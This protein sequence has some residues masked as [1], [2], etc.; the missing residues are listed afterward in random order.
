LEYKRV[1]EEGLRQLEGLERIQT[2]FNKCEVA[3]P[4]K[5]VASCLLFMWR[6]IENDDARVD[7]TPRGRGMRGMPRRG[8]HRSLGAGKAGRIGVEKRK[9]RKYLVHRDLFEQL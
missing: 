1:I 2:L 7:D 5:T 6:A 9:T 8:S 4:R 3:V